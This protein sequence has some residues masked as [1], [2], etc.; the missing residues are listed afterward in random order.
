MLKSKLIQ[1]LITKIVVSKDKI[2][3]L[4]LL[5]KEPEFGEMIDELLIAVG[6]CRRNS[7]N[8]IEFL[9]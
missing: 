2:T 7:D 1:E 6:V 8:N 5:R 3:E 9:L 4:E